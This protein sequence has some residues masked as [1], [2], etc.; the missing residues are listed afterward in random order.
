[1]TKGKKNPKREK[2]EENPKRDSLPAA[3]MLAPRTSLGPATAS[4]MEQ[5]QMTAKGKSEK[6]TKKKRAGTACR[7]PTGKNQENR[8]IRLEIAEE[9]ADGFGVVVDGGAAYFV[10]VEAGVEGVGCGIGRVEIDF[11][12]DAGVAGGFGALEKFGVERAGVALAAGGGRRD[13]AIDVHEIG[14]GVFLEEP[15][16]TFGAWGTQRT[17]RGVLLEGVFEEGSEPEK[18]YV[19]VARGLVEG[20]EQSV[21]IVDGG[22]K[23]GLADE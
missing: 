9:V 13:Y 17:L 21:R 12:G 2:P 7:A 10:E 8:K 3:G 1:M 22:G 19:L 14:V 4:G 23:K 20:D 16:P 11:A 6:R 18:I 15:T 5:T